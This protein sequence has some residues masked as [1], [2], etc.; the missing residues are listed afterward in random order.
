VF[1]VANAMSAAAAVLVKPEHSHCSFLLADWAFQSPGTL[2][3]VL[4]TAKKHVSHVLGKLGA[5]NRTEAVARAR[6]LG[7]IRWHGTRAANPGWHLRA[8]VPA[9]EDSPRMCTFG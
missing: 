8:S 2:R 1:V 9:V 5:A 7:L 6:Q 4:D 3:S